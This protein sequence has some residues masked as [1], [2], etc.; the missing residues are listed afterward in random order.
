VKNFKNI[1]IT[2]LYFSGIYIFKASGTLMP[3]SKNIELFYI[4]ALSDGEKTASI[5]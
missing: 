1:S 4:F 3:R 2:Y 5:D